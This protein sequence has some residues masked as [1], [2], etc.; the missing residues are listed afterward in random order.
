MAI[1][2]IK[3]AEARFWEAGFKP[4]KVEGDLL[5]EAYTE[6]E[7]ENKKKDAIKQSLLRGK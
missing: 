6:W 2:R 1:N 5:W 4:N 3:G 7:E